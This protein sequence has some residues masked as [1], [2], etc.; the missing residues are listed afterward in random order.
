MPWDNSRD[1]SQKL[2]RQPRVARPVICGKSFSMNAPLNLSGEWIVYYAGHFDEVI[3]ITQTGD[4]VEAVKITGDDHVPA[5]AVTWRADLQTGQGEGQIAEKEFRNPRFVP[6]ELIIVN[7]ER[8][9]FRW[10]KC[11]QVEY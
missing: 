1:E 8:I 4:E 11:G 5:G 10:E 6:G 9:I 7:G 2:Y 3:Q